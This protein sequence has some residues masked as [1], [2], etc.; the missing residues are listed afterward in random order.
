MYPT[1]GQQRAATLWNVMEQQTRPPA[2]VSERWSW[3]FS[4]VERFE[5]RQTREKYYAALERVTRRGDH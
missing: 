5:G 1:I 4:Y 3:V 2:R